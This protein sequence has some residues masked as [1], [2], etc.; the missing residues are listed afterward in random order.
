MHLITVGSG[1]LRCLLDP[2]PGFERPRH[3]GACDELVGVWVRATQ[4]STAGTACRSG[5]RSVPSEALDK[6]ERWVSFLRQ[7]LTKAGEGDV[8]D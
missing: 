1:P 7:L 6:D 2:R 5:Q 4:R 3:K 8:A